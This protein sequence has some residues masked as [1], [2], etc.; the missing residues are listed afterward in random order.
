MELGEPRHDES[1]PCRTFQVEFGEH[2]VLIDEEA[3]HAG[4]PEDAVHDI[5]PALEAAHARRPFDRATVGEPGP[6]EREPGRYQVAAPRGDVTDQVGMSKRRWVTLPRLCLQ[7]RKP[8]PVDTA[9]EVAA[10]AHVVA[11]RIPAYV[12]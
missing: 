3:G 9:R 2:V 7:A 10:E 12:K 11:G 5:R 6:R 4:R 1:R 8:C